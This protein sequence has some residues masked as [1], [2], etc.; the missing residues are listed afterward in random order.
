MANTYQ[1]LIFGDPNNGTAVGTIPANKVL[2]ICHS[3][4]DICKGESIVKSEHLNVSCPF[5]CM[6]EDI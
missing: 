3:E 6:A 2:V 4:D 5:S 1:V